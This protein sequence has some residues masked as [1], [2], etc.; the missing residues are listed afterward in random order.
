MQTYGEVAAFNPALTASAL[1]PLASLSTTSSLESTS[2]RYKP[3]TGALLTSA[4]YTA[5]TTLSRN[6]SRNSSSVRSRDPSLT[7]IIS[8]CG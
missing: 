1:L 6:S 2:L 5:R 3:R 7:T 8:N 4:M